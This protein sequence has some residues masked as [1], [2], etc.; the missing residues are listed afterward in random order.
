ML[1]ASH[2]L[3]QHPLRTPSSAWGTVGPPLCAVRVTLD[4]V[5]L[6]P[7]LPSRSSAGGCPPL[8]GPFAGTTAQSDS[9]AAYTW[10]VRHAPYPTGLPV[11]QSV[12]EVSRFS[13]REFSDVHKFF[14]R[15]GAGRRSRW[16][17][18]R[19]GLPLQEVGCQAACR[20]RRRMTRGQRG[21]LLLRCGAP[22]SPTLR[23]FIP[24]LSE[25]LN[26]RPTRGP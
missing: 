2:A 4:G 6:G 3:Q 5:L 17:G 18:G 12:A 22:S 15:A 20:H 7:T 8:F 10:G 24:A 26:N 9:S 25:P 19:C 14:D 21:S 16:R 23:R 13:R 1:A 11:R